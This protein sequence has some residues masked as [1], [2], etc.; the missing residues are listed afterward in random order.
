MKRNV[1]ALL[2]LPAVFPLFLARLPARAIEI[3][4]SDGPS[5]RAQVG[6]RITQILAIAVLSDPTWANYPLLKRICG[7]ESNDGPDS[8]P[9]QFDPGTDNPRWGWEA[10]STAPGGKVRVQRD[11]GACQINIKAHAD[12]LAALHLD[13]IHSLA[14]NVAYAKLLFDREGWEPWQASKTGWDPKDLVH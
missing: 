5:Y 9:L 7:T 12:E 13:V 14:D 8:E 6:T 4:P 1:F 10:S 11:V 2:F 3:T